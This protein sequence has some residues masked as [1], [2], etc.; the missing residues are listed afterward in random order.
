MKSQEM[1]FDNF[2]NIFGIFMN[3]LYF[4]GFLLNF[5]IFFLVHGMLLKFLQQQFA[6]TIFFG[7]SILF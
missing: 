5:Y 2:F 1:F 6:F 4:F 7:A 3:F